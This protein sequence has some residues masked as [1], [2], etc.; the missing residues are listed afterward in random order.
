M[1]EIIKKFRDL[2]L[3]FAPNETCSTADFDK[4][5]EALVVFETALLEVKEKN[6]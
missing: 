4:L 5:R 1:Y 3:N 2:E 6:R